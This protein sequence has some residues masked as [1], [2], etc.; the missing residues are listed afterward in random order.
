MPI[1]LRNYAASKKT[2][3]LWS[4]GDFWQKSLPG[5]IPTLIFSRYREKVDHE[6]V[7]FG[8]HKNQER[9]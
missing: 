5:A 3:R 7:V 8:W 9:S 6:T 2:G 1:F 4:G